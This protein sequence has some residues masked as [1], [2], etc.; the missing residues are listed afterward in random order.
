MP[1]GMNFESFNHKHLIDYEYLTDRKRAFDR[2]IVKF[3]DYSQ[4]IHIIIMANLQCV[5]GPK[6]D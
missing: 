1:F 5:R 3:T 6:F 2:Y 4:V